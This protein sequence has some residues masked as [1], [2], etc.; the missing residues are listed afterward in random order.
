MF[1]D[2]FFLMIRRPPRST[3]TDTLFPYTTLFRSDDPLRRNAALP[4]VEQAAEE[5]RVDRR[6]ERRV[7]QHDEG[8]A[9]SQ[10]HDRFLEIAARA[11]GDRRARALASGN[12]DPDDARIVDEPGD[13]VVR[14]ENIGEDSGWRACAFER[15]E[16]HPS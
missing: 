1:I 5:R 9:A 8:I 15:S 4:R 6:L 11:F 2:V 16:E 14:G 7:G 10:F 3:R 12:G 13:L